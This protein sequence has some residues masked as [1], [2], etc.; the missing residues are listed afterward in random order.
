MMLNRILIGKLLG[1]WPLGKLKLKWRWKDN[2]KMD[3]MEVVCN[4]RSWIELSFVSHN[5]LHYCFKRCLPLLLRDHSFLS[6]P[7]HLKCDTFRIFIWWNQ[8]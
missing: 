8:Y 3:L 6:H 5:P 1:M 2:I 4:D 7:L